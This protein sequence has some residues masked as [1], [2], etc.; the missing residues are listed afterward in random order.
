MTMRTLQDFWQTSEMN[1]H[2][3]IEES[4]TI[5]EEIQKDWQLAS[6]IIS[7]KTKS[8]ALNG[9]GLYAH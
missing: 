2:K 7:K 1:Y 8:D 5:C 9:S 4:S 3:I 6:T